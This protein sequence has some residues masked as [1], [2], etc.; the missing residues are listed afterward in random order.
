MSEGIP[1][2]MYL[3]KRI[4]YPV[5]TLMRSGYPTVWQTGT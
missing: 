3:E 1:V 4:V 5:Q 2:P